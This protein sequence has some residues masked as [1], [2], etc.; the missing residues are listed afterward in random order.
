MRPA[1]RPNV[2]NIDDEVGKA[3]KYTVSFE[4]YPE[5]E[6][7]DFS[8]IKLERDVAEISEEDVNSGV[9]KLQKQFATWNEVDRAAKS[10]DKVTI[11]FVGYIDGEAF[12]GGTANDMELELGSGQ[13]IP[14]FEDGLIKS[15][16][17]DSKTLDLTFPKDYGSNKLAGKKTEFKVEVKKVKESVLAELNKDFAEK[18]GIEDGTPEKIKEQV[19]T[20]MVKY[21]EDLTNNKLRE[22]VFDK[23]YE[24][25]KFE[26]PTSLVEQQKDTLR[27][28]MKGNNTDHDHVHTAD[29]NHEE[30]KLSAKEEKELTEKAEKSVAIGLLLNEII[31]KHDIKPDKEKAEQK[32]R[33]MAAMYGGANPEMIQKMY[34]ES[35]ELMQNIFNMVLTDQAADLIVE[36]ATIKDKKRKFYDIVDEKA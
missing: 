18:I 28:E 26:L 23:L 7:K 12:E 8:A 35:K 10:G 30:E 19:K 16:A 6:L 31:T 25:N 34:Y 33:S 32:I 22:S 15:K 21:V 11:D 9:E 4:V 5:I 17:G 20:N 14:G 1:N 27:K 2:E 13:F 3:L 29:C 24:V 36:N